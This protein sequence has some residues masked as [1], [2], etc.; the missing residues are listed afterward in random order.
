MSAREINVVVVGGSWAGVKAIRT[1]LNLVQSDYPNLRVTLVERRAHY[2]HITGAIRGM[3]DPSYAQRM[4]I[5]YD[6]MF[7][8]AGIPNASHTFI[9]G[10]LAQAHGRFIDL[11]SGQRIFFDYLILSTGSQYHSLPVVQSTHYHEAQEL[12]AS[13]RASIQRAKRI[14]VV[15]GGAVGVGLCGEIADHYPDKTLTIGH[16]RKHLLNG[17]LADSFASSAEK[18]LTRMG[19]RLMLGETVMPSPNSPRNFVTPDALQVFTTKSGKTIECD[20]AIWT[21]GGR[22]E[23]CYMST[24]A[25]SNWER[26]LVDA[27]RNRI[28]VRP[29]LQLDDDLYPHI[30][31][32]GD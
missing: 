21:T 28:H 26:P 6:R 15:G 7:S 12:F 1:L 13:M 8:T 10:T 29:T 23:T 16:N 22:P 19:V 18:K 32:I 24:L 27:V 11:E 20:L 3:V 30:F 31:A 9:Q 25:P 5:P 17:D 4:C 14:L 2:F